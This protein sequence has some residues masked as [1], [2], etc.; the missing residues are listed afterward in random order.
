MSHSL[1]EIENV[2]KDMASLVERLGSL[3]AG[4]MGAKKEELPEEAAVIEEATQEEEAVVTTTEVAAT[5]ESKEEPAQTTTIASGGENGKVS[6]SD[7][8]RSYFD[9][10]GINTRNKDVVEGI[11]NE[12][13]VKVEPSMVSF[14]RSRLAR[15]AD[16]K[17]ASKKMASKKMVQVEVA[18]KKK[19]SGSSH[20]KSYFESHG[21]DVANEDIVSYI[22]KSKGVDVKPT[23]VSSVRAIL[24]KKG[25]KG[26]KVGAKKTAKKAPTMPSVVVEVLKRAPKDGLELSQVAS[27]ALKSGYEYRGK[28]DIAGFTQNVYQALNNLSKKIAHPG[29]KGA[30]AVVLHE[31][32]KYKLNPKAMRDKV[33]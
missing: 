1:K 8:I 3:L 9:K 12:H 28:K 33:A 32:R 30:T 16:Q 25:F 20:I 21:L 4:I 13:H 14:L 7:L 11:K 18:S 2:R 23:L 26:G 22:K 15:K 31:G 27:R 17:A 10:H 29:Y 6:K 24:K 19:T 5:E